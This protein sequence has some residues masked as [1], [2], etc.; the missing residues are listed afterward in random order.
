MKFKTKLAS[1]N[2]ASCNPRKPL[3]RNKLILNF[4]IAH[5]VPPQSAPDFI[6]TM[7]R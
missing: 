2:G 4:D 6:K 1:G 5:V 7:P 3:L